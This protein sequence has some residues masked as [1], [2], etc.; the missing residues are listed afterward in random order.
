MATSM[1]WPVQLRIQTYVVWNGH[2]PAQGQYYF[3]DPCD[4][5]CFVK[6]VKQDSL[7]VHPHISPYVHTE[8][9]FGESICRARDS[10]ASHRRN[11]APVLFI[12]LPELEEGGAIAGELGEGEGVE[13]PAARGGRWGERLPAMSSAT[14]VVVEAAEGGGRRWWPGGGGG[15]AVSG[16]EAALGRPGPDNLWAVAGGGGEENTMMMN[17]WC[18][19]GGGGRRRRRRKSQGRRGKARTEDEGFFYDSSARALA[20]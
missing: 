2:E 13:R 1:R 16:G 12:F 3:A 20:S 18:G 5:V 10:R 17:G 11:R 7:Y 8:W 14:R 15:S 9:N 19:G 4:L 6:L